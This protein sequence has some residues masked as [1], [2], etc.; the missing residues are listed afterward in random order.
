[1]S[2]I[3]AGPFYKQLPLATLTRRI[4]YFGD[5]IQRVIGWAYRK[6]RL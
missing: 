3:S 6:C 5:A 2:I 1:M 4:T